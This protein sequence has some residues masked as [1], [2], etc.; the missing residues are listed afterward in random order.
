MRKQR[1]RQQ[2]FF[3]AAGLLLLAVLA[4]CNNPASGS[5]QGQKGPA[6]G[7]LSGKALFA[8]GN[9]HAGIDITLEKTEGL[10]PSG[11]ISQAVSTDQGARGVS[12]AFPY[13]ARTETDAE[14]SF[15]FSNVMP[16]TYTV[17]ASSRDAVEKAVKI[18]LTVVSGENADAG[19][20]KLT[21]AG[22]LRGRVTLD[23][24]SGGNFGF[25]V[26]IADTSFMAATDMEGNFTISGIPAGTY[27]VIIIKGSSTVV[28]TENGI[29]LEV[30]VNGGQ[31]TEL[32]NKALTGEDIINGSGAIGIGAN[33]NWFINGAD[34]GI[35]A[36]AND[37][38][39]GGSVCLV[40]FNANGGI[41]A[42]GPLALL[43]GASVDEPSDVMEK[44]GFSFEGW[45]LDRGCTV[46]ASF[47]LAV[48]TDIALYAK[49][50]EIPGFAFFNVRFVSNGG[51][52]TADLRVAEHSPAERPADPVKSG[53]AF[54]GWHSDMGLTQ[55]YD[56]SEPLSRSIALFAA[57]TYM[58][59][60]PIVDLD[61]L[62]FYLEGQS[63][64]ASE[65]DPVYLSLQIRLNESN[66]LFI[67]EAIAARD[68]FVSL[69]LSPCARSTVNYGGGLRSGGTFDPVNSVSTGKD[70][71]RS[72][73]LPDAA[74]SLVPGAVGKTPFSVFENLTA[75]NGAHVTDIGIYALSNCDSLTGFNFPELENIGDYAFSGCTG[76]ESA[77]LGTVLAVI[78]DGAF[79]GCNNLSTLTVLNPMPPELGANAFNDTWQYKYMEIRVPEGSVESYQSSSVWDTYADIIIAIGSTP[80]PYTLLLNDNGLTELG[81]SVSFSNTESIHE[82]TTLSGTVKVYYTLKNS[83]KDINKLV[84]SFVDTEDVTIDTVG[85][86][87]H[88][89]K[90][91]QDDTLN[92][93]IAITVEFFH[94]DI[95]IGVPFIGRH[96]WM[97]FPHSNYISDPDMLRVQVIGTPG[98]VAELFDYAGVKIPETQVVLDSTGIAAIQVP[99]SYYLSSAGIGNKGVQLAASSEVRVIAGIE[100]NTSSTSW[101]V[102]KSPALRTSYIAFDPISNNEGGQFVIIGTEADTHVT[103]SSS[104]VTKDSI[105][106]GVGQTWQYYS[107]EAISGWNIAS[108]KPIAV[109]TGNA[110]NTYPGLN[111]G[112]AIEQAPPVKYWGRMYAVAPTFNAASTTPRANHIVVASQ[113]NTTVMITNSNGNVITIRL[114]ANEPNMFAQN[115][116]DQHGYF[117][118]ADKPILV[119]SRIADPGTAIDAVMIVWPPL[120]RPN[121]SNLWHMFIGYST[122]AMVLP[123]PNT[124][125]FTNNYLTV[126]TRTS[127]T[128]NIKING[129][130]T[131]I[132]DWHAIFSTGCSFARFNVPAGT[133]EVVGLNGAVFAVVAAGGG[134]SGAS[135]AYTGPYD[136]QLHD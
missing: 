8:G 126:I 45:F 99:N 1:R 41:P 23:G 49:W 136:V 59:G 40:N 72:L 124:A 127:D 115:T 118:D 90:L 27:H 34:T 17:Y 102:W 63:G 44:N 121:D 30:T 62:A 48:N 69:D 10:R 35:K 31:M 18:N 56:F 105:I 25:A 109:L 83:D 123:N 66:W 128:S 77:T 52:E 11:S 16:G 79:I 29:P 7:S 80:I 73:T 131:S 94:M 67:L 116:N 101:S 71:I 57:W 43:Q 32:G 64:G 117:I 84:L 5:A 47:P 125:L 100:H 2:A 28:W 133:N 114:N 55:P 26:C 42:P 122:G 74:V 119:I 12:A 4:S 87:L 85:N 93:I 104:G 134:E 129:V 33:G 38:K 111:G 14:G 106:L 113:D 39:E 89:Y 82:A 76:L 103:I 53:Y 130:V 81:D 36:K 24:A 60:L 46:P 65:E 88:A 37:G 95:P 54:A 61:D 107:M 22:S 68:A 19:T 98:T 108:D 92:G 3:Y 97:A 51:S 9:D 78:G 6:P 96:F 75:I 20:L 91:N 132:A 58:S 15:L 21:A 70:K 135:Y 86:G 112:L 110:G 120:Y 13:A 50:E